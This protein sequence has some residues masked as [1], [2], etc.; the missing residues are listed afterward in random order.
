MLIAKKSATVPQISEGVHPAICYS[1]IDC[2]V[3][4]NTNFDKS[5][6]KVMLMWE[7]PDETYTYEGEERRRV[8]SKEYTLSLNDLSKLRGDLRGWRGRDFTPEEFEGFSLDKLLGVGCQLHIIHNDKG[9]AKIQSVLPLPKGTKLGDPINKL[10]MLDLDEDSPEQITSKLDMLP[11]WIRKKI[12]DSET[13]QKAMDGSSN[14]KSSDADVEMVEDD[15][16]GD[17]SF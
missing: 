3:Q 15:E 11:E 6:R 2:G 14:A 5:S 7:L 17:L 1:V 13:Y 9:Y 10:L 12:T 8:I 16:D 4:Y